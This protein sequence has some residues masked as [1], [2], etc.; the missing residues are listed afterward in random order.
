MHMQN[1]E[2]NFESLP[3]K[4]VVSEL[5]TLFLF[6]KQSQ[7]TTEN[8]D[9]DAGTE[10]NQ[11]NNNFQFT[12]DKHTS[13]F[14]KHLDNNTVSDFATEI[15]NTETV[16]Q[17]EL[18]TIS[19][20]ETEKNSIPNQVFK[21]ETNN[22]TSEQKH[23]VHKVELSA[24]NSVFQY[25]LVAMI[26]FGCCF[27]TSFFTF[28]FVLIPVEVQG[29][30]MYPTINSSAMG[31]NAEFYNDIVYISKSKKVEYKDIIIIKE[32]KT[33]SGKQL[34]KRVIA[35]P[36]QTITFKRVGTEF[37]GLQE[38]FLVDIYI[39]GEKLEE[40]Y[41][42]ESQTKIQN[43]IE[44]SSYY[45]FNN[46]IVS[47]LQYNETDKT[48]TQYSLTL[49]D[50]EYFVMGDNRNGYISDDERDHG[51]VDSRM[52]GPIKQDEIVGK[53][54][55]HIEYGESILQSIWKQLF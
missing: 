48:N 41:T 46:K 53:V 43:L 45:Q 1:Q 55:L 8:K 2:K 10:N 52:F 9:V 40:D 26:V 3:D 24:L 6:E 16:L 50:D 38:Y 5:G 7:S 49:A 23:S 12:Q 29:Y 19:T 30:S 15:S 21:S 35:T 28:N 4:A 18:E 22:R 39:D 14:H 54:C 25:L 37:V 44:S 20:T 11:T 32:G 34:I 47:A 42:K 36:E 51:S 13:D 31:E 33:P 27:V 17:P